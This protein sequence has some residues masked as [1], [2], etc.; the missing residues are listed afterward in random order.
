MKKAIK[1]FVMSVMV[2]VLYAVAA[3]IGASFPPGDG[4]TQT[5]P[6]RKDSLM[7]LQEAKVLLGTAEQNN[8][9]AA[10]ME[11][12]KSE[13]PK[14]R[15]IIKERRIYVPVKQKVLERERTVPAASTTAKKPV[16]NIIYDA[17]KYSGTPTREK[18]T[19]SE[20]KA[21]RGLLQS[22]SYRL[23]EKYLNDGQGN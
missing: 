14:E 9:V 6:V 3:L 19:Y 2:G 18:L 13:K 20:W 23:Y 12:V 7:S 8:Q 1:I 5:P 17:P 10:A 11:S 22:K 21:Q 4:N 15:V 16:V